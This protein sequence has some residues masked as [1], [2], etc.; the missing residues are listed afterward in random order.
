MLLRIRDALLSSDYTGCLQL[1]LR[2]PS[3][4]DGDLRIS[5]LLRQAIFLRDD[6]SSAAGDRCCEENLREGA[7]A[8]VAMDDGSL[9]ARERQGVSKGRV[10]QPVAPTPGQLAGSAAAALLAEGG[11]LVGDLAKG[12]YRGFF[13]DRVSFC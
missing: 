9:E 7:A 5:L 6:V 4:R 8:G 1:L 3:P 2:Y 13:N 10:S 11:G 12:V